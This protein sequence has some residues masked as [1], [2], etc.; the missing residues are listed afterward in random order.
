MKRQL[1]LLLFCIIFYFLTNGIVYNQEIE[2]PQDSLQKARNL[3]EDARVKSAERGIEVLIRNVDI[4]KYPLVKIIVEAYNTFGYPLDTLVAENLTVMEDG[5]EKKVISV[6]KISVNERVPVDFIFAIDKT[7][8]MQKY[9]DD[10]KKNIIGFTT[11]LVRRGIDYNLGLILF[12]DYVEE[13]YELTDNV[14]EF[15]G[16]LNYVQAKGGYD[17]KENALEALQTACDF[18]FRPSA[19]KVAVIITDAPYHQKGEEGEGVT[20][21]TTAT[22]IELMKDKDLRLFTIA[23]PKLKNYEI[24]SKNTR[25]TFFD[26]DY[27]FSTILDIF[28]NQLT[29]VYALTYRTDQESIPDSINIAL[30]NEKKQQLV[31]KIIPIVE[32]G[33]KLIIENLLYKTGSYELP[34]SVD[35]L[36]VL[37]YFMKNRPNVVI[38]VEG[39]TDSIG[40]YALNDR[41]SKNRAESVKKYL[42]KKGIN[43]KR[44]RTK[45]YGERKPIATNSTEFGRKLNRR[46]EI[47][48]VGK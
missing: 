46:T 10:V 3:L 28:S 34:D 35:E 40:S 33:R 21:Q 6:E 24:M 17:E 15:L 27:P 25:G 31:R 26:I 19:N 43:P 12:S 37:T 14:L 29:S 11:N 22:I 16:W 2:K 23:P 36:E 30:L 9:I 18:N 48:I 32:L 38:L 7:G 20:D 1:Y 5:V 41:L 39:H 45:G 44:I 42:I 4:S 8:S 13:T 47:V